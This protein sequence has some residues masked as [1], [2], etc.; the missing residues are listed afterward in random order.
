[1]HIDDIWNAGIPNGS[2][3]VVFAS[4]IFLSCIDLSILKVT[5]LN[6]QHNIKNTFACCL[7]LHQ[8][9]QIQSRKMQGYASLSQKVLKGVV[10]P[11]FLN[12]IHVKA[13]DFIKYL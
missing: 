6:I 3:L 2:K 9:T 13:V 5:I 10:S 7:E 12:G 11:L 4:H 8:P 1:M